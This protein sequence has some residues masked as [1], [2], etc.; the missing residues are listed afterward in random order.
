MPQEALEGLETDRMTN[1][2]LVKGDKRVHI[3]VPDDQVQA[4]MDM[5]YQSVDFSVFMNGRDDDLV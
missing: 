3:K 1:F 2:I 4:F 5:V